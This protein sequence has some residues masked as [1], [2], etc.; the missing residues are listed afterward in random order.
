MGL[1]ICLWDVLRVS[2]GLI[3]QGDGTV[4]VNIEFRMVVFRPYKGEIIQGVILESHASTGLR[5][6]LDFFADVFVPVSGLP[7]K[8]KLV[9]PTPGEPDSKAI[10]AWDE[11][12]DLDNAYFYEQYEIVRFRVEEEIWNDAS[13]EKPDFQKDAN[14]EKSIR[15]KIEKERGDFKK[16][17]EKELA[18]ER[19]VPYAIV[20]SLGAPGL[21]C[22]NWWREEEAEPE[23]DAIGGAEEDEEM[24]D[25]E[26]TTYIE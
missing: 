24:V 4:N 14:G 2:E 13:P 22:V 15:E 5:I 17:T 19:P 12:N 7:A 8:S 16:K 3:G 6:G 10:W 20:A 21:G 18:M 9:P 1:C 26:R 25:G 23:L 11:N